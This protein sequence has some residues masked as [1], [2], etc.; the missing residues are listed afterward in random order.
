M[1]EMLKWCI[2]ISSKL[3]CSY[4]FMFLTGLLSNAISILPLKG[5]TMATALP[6]DFETRRSGDQSFLFENS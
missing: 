4:Y 5:S 2:V 1:D 6:R 3:N